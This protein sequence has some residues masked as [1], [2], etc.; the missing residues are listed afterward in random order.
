ML[1]LAVE[2]TA[3]KGVTGLFGGAPFG[4]SAP[5]DMNILL[6]GRDLRGIH[7]GDSIPHVFIPK[8][9][10]LYRSGRFPIDR[11]VR[12]YAFADINKAFADAASGTVIK[13]VLVMDQ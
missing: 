10:E 9:V 11:M 13:P 5:I 7:Q 6:A 4:T 3:L 2:L 1:A 8:L 12:T